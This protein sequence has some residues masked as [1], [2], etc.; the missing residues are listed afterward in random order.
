MKKL[1]LKQHWTVAMVLMCGGLAISTIDLL[2]NFATFR[3]VPMI[4]AFVLVIGGYLY[5]RKFVRCPD[6]GS[7]LPSTMK[8]P[9]K[10]EQCD[11][12]LHEYNK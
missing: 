2:R 3:P 5:H 11:K 7:I 6:C 10:C 1:T 4:S 9:E 12:S 8:F